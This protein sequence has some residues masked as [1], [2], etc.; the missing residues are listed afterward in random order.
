MS[1]SR[2]WTAAAKVVALMG[3]GGDKDRRYC[4]VPKSPLEASLEQVKS[5]KS[6][7]ANACSHFKPIL[8]PAAAARSMDSR[9]KPLRSMV[10]LPVRSKCAC[11]PC[12]VCEGVPWAGCNL[13]LVS[14][15]WQQYEMY[16]LKGIS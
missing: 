12:C 16:G 4:R 10:N 14:K 1:L 13:Q 8:S 11:Q 5:V 6:G 9:M 7:W 3:H 15:R 2:P